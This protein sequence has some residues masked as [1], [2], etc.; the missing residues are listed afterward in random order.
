M[1]LGNF[2]PAIAPFCV[3]GSL[4]TLGIHDTASRHLGRISS[5]P[6]TTLV[7][8]GPYR[9]SCMADPSCDPRERTAATQDYIASTYLEAGSYDGVLN[10]YESSAVQAR[11][12][13]AGPKDAIPFLHQAQEKYLQPFITPFQSPLCNNSSLWGLVHATD[14][15]LGEAYALGGVHHCYRQFAAW[16]TDTGLEQII[17]SDPGQWIFFIEATRQLEGEHRQ[18]FETRQN[19]M[20]HFHR[21]A[22]GLGIPVENSLLPVDSEEV[23][24]AL[25]REGLSRPRQAS[26]ASMA[27][28]LNELV[29]SSPEVS[30][31]SYEQ[32]SVFVYRN[33]HAYFVSRALKLPERIEDE[34][35][36][37]RA[38]EQDFFAV[39]KR[40]L[41]KKPDQSYSDW[42]APLKEELERDTLAATQASNRLSAD[43]I[44]SIMNGSLRKKAF[45][46]MGS[47]HLPLM[48]L[49]YE[50]T[51]LSK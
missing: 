50:K 32:R 45:L 25:E 27:T 35:K 34:A 41:Q 11:M 7:T 37:Y 13:L 44:K 23:I 33:L 20:A 6:N 21:V 5:H 15:T 2:R 40:R 1:S 29:T 16:F 4:G 46:Q 47:G 38:D 22:E 19:E 3:L 10:I 49:A 8:E 18:G 24:A 26:T 17:A 42:F 12:L 48:S 9:K 39:C 14:A 31:M 51:V 43:R 30:R 28:V 36:L